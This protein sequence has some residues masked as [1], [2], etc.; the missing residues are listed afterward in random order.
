MWKRSH[1][2][3]EINVFFYE[4]SVVVGNVESKRYKAASRV[5]ISGL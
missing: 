1:D 3:R 4:S 5:G 2:D